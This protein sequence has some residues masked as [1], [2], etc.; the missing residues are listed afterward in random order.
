LDRFYGEARIEKGTAVSLNTKDVGRETI[1]HCSVCGRIGQLVELP[2]RIDKSCLACSA[3]L[4]TATL[5]I[6]EIV[7]ATLAGRNT[8]ALASECTESGRRML[9]RAQFAGLEF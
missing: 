2:G 5:L 6:T 7:A 4:A 8:N 3:D 1:G 9:E